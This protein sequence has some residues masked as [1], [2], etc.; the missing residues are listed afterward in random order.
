[1]GH[2][3][4]TE[5]ANMLIVQRVQELALK[6]GVTMAQVAIAW[7]FAKGVT[8]PIIGATKLEHLQDAV[9]GAELKLTEEDVKYLEEKYVAHELKGMVLHP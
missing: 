6:Y 3:D 9:K 4:A 7:Q 2:Y 8:A 1:M 5:A